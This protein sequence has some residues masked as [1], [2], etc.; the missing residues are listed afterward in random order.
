VSGLT[1]Q[2]SHCTCPIGEQNNI[3]QSFL[4]IS[5]CLRRRARA[6]AASSSG[7]VVNGGV[8]TSSGNNI[9]SS[10]AN[11]DNSNSNVNPSY[12][13]NANN[14]S[15]TSFNLSSESQQWTELEYIISFKLFYFFWKNL[16][17]NYYLMSKR[18]DIKRRSTEKKAIILYYSLY[19]QRKY[20]P[21]KDKTNLYIKVLK[22]YSNI[23]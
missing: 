10:G 8:S 21:I 2:R 16:F 11:S 18:E 4:N 6:R 1:F 7:S 13:I 19:F 3:R 17:A 5:T 23:D 20:M 12:S 9:N 14:N 15:Y 22:V